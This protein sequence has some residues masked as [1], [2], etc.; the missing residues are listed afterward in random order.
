[1]FAKTLFM[2]SGFLFVVPKAIIL[3]CCIEK[4]S[5]IEYALRLKLQAYSFGHR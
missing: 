4:P 5:F 3:L 1:M 2:R